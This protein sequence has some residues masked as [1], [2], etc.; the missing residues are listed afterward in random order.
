MAMSKGSFLLDKFLHGIASVRAWCEAYGFREEEIS[1]MRR[2]KMP[3]LRTA[4]KL[5]RAT[6]GRVPIDA[7][8]VPHPELVKKNR[9]PRVAA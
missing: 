7:W 3:S 4:G 9:S 6:K 2:G 5:K 8:L 1:R